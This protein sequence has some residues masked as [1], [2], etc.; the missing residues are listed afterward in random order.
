MKPGEKLTQGGEV[1]ASTT[2]CQNCSPGILI[3][4]QG[5]KPLPESFVAFIW[6]N[7]VSAFL[8]K[9]TWAGE[10]ES[11]ETGLGVRVAPGS[12]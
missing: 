4:P 8:A 3:V 11:G 9:P 12:A 10:Q 2:H 1:M 5:T 7:G 6:E